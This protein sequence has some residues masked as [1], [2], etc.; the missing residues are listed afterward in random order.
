MVMALTSTL[1]ASANED[2]EGRRYAEYLGVPYPIR[3]TIPTD[4]YSGQNPNS[5]ASINSGAYYIRNKR[6]GQYLTAVDITNGYGGTLYGST[7]MTNYTGEANQLWQLNV[8]PPINLNGVELEIYFTLRPMSAGASSRLSVDGVEGNSVASNTFLQNGTNIIVTHSYD[9]NNSNINQPS[10]WAASQTNDGSYIVVTRKS[11][12]YALSINDLSK[13]KYLTCEAGID[14]VMQRSSYIYT[15]GSSHWFFE[16]APYQ[17]VAY[18]GWLDTVDSSKIRG[19]AYDPLNPDRS[20]TVRIT[21]EDSNGAIY[22]D[23][24]VAACLYRADLEAAGMGNGY[25]GFEHSFDWNSL[26]AGAY[27]IKAYANG[28]MSCKLLVSDNIDK[29]FTATGAMPATENALYDSYNWKYP[30]RSG[31]S[32]DYRVSAWWGDE[33]YDDHSGLDVGGLRQGEY[34]FSPTNG[35]VCG[36]GTQASAGY[37]V[38][39]KTKHKVMNQNDDLR[40]GVVHLMSPPTLQVGDVVTSETILGYVGNTGTSTGAH[41]HIQVTHNN[42][43][44][45]YG[46]SNTFAPNVFFP[47]IPFHT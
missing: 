24:R 16:A 14:K 44:S 47:D 31:D 11:Y 26:P 32:N 7:I 35:V 38:I 2:E 18:N 43:N 41:L 45:A 34:V 28:N 25:H 6:T 17:P 12:E 20:I 27:I 13:Q 23:R 30:L 3:H 40:I 19:W 9:P 10:H 46:K 42:Q 33:T 36:V 21:I 4:S 5:R 37:Y 22:Y 8:E 29:T 39:I 15:D 1:I